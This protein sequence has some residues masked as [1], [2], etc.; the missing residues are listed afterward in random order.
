MPIGAIAAAA[1]VSLVQSHLA[2]KASD[3]ASA[4]AAQA[5]R[6]EL[7]FAQQQYQDFRN[8]YGDVEANLGRFYRNLSPDTFAIQGIEAFEQEQ[9]RALENVQQSLAQRGLTDSGISADLERQASIESAETRA[10]IRTQAPLQV[11]EAQQ[12]FV[13]SGRGG[14][15]ENLQ[16]T[17]SNRATRSLR[18]A[19][20]AESRSRS[21]QG[22]TA[23]LI[24]LGID[25][26]ANQPETA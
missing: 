24:A 18:T 12:A 16:R 10:R 8:V 3:R 2:G 15:A 17:L 7:E 23:R 26:I 11:A 14:Q 19:E 13:A 21:A 1:G 9:A 4:R 22:A 25:E 20:I 5:S 6:E